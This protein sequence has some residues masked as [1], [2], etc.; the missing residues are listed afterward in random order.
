MESAESYIG[1]VQSHCRMEKGE[2]KNVALK[3]LHNLIA[4]SS[5]GEA[6]Y[7][8]AYLAFQDYNSF[9]PGRG[10]DVAPALAGY[11]AWL[12]LSLE[13]PPSC[14]E[15]VATFIDPFG[16]F[17]TFTQVGVGFCQGIAKAFARKW[18][19]SAAVHTL[20][21]LEQMHH[22]GASAPA[23][24]NFQRAVTEDQSYW[25][26]T[27]KCA[28]LLLRSGRYLEAREYAW[29]AIKAQSAFDI[30]GVR[31][32]AAFVVLESCQ[33]SYII[34]QQEGDQM[35]AEKALAALIE[36]RDFGWID[37]LRCSEL[38]EEVWLLTE[39][40]DSTMGQI[41]ESELEDLLEAQITAQGKAFGRS[42]A[43][44]QPHWRQVRINDGRG[45]IDLLARDI[46]EDAHVVI[47]LKGGRVDDDAVEQLLRYL[48]WA[49]EKYSPQRVTGI[50]CGYSVREEVR[51]ILETTSEHAI[52]AWEY[53][54]VDENL[55]LRRVHPA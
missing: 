45:R 2:A 17:Y 27:V 28:E 22:Q 39:Y 46:D 47:E 13:A 18:P 1:L 35:T 50:L 3:R 41:R 23:I 10:R 40:L 16:N 36:L 33:G 38:I 34:A 37:H 26:A 55:L 19:D 53:R 24:E 8:Q 43:L 15:L 12:S 31:S 32:E 25:L 20:R 44:A 48:D 5:S 49:K 21:G 4:N 14:D 30:A 29:Q 9:V 42:L 6:L 51:Q 54:Y 52:E 7:V 11:A